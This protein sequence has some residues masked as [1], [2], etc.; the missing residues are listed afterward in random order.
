MKKRIAVILVVVSVIMAVGCVGSIALFSRDT[1]GYAAWTKVPIT[2][3]QYVGL[4]DIVDFDPQKIITD[5]DYVFSG[6]IINRSEYKIK[7]QDEKKEQWGPFRKSILE[8]R[9][10]KEYFGESPTEN[11]VIKIYY[12]YSLSMTLEDSFLLKDDGEYVFITQALDEEFVEYRNTNSPED[13]FGQE[14]FADVYISDPCFHVMPIEN[15]HVIMYRDYFSWDAKAVKQINS[16]DLSAT[17]KIP[18]AELAEEG[19]YISMD[20]ENFDTAFPQLFTKPETIPDADTL[21]KM[22]INEAS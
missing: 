8:V 7:W 11:D 22:R 1:S 14:R 3:G 16:G 6:T 18:S 17:D 21:K 12:P 4:S 13:K 19:L 9:V 2:D 5:A 10:N 15:D 20:A